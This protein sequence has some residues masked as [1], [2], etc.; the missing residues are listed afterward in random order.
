MSD[1]P[2]RLA[3]QLRLELVHRKVST[4]NTVPQLLS[5]NQIASLYEVTGPPKQAIKWLE[6]LHTRVLHD[7]GVLARLGAVH[8]KHDDE[9]KALH[10]FSEAHRVYP[11]SRTGRSL[12]S[13]FSAFL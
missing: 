11:V 13:P 6:M 2:A 7:P 10:Y 12:S 5:P 4:A 9:A 8:S 1:S 3:Y